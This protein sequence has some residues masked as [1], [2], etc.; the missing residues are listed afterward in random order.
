MLGTTYSDLRTGSALAKALFNGEI[1]L[2]EFREAVEFLEP[3]AALLV[4]S[5]MR[6]SAENDPQARLWEARAICARVAARGLRLS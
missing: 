3:E 6:E 4:A 1:T 2:S 5:A